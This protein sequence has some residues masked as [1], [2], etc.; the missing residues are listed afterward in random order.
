MKKS[1]LFILLALLMNTSVYGT[2]YI[3]DLLLIGGT[4]DEVCQEEKK[5]QQQGWETINKDLNEGCGESTDYIYLMA[6][7]EESNGVN[8]G[9]VTDV[10]LYTSEPDIDLLEYKGTVYYLTPYFGGSHFRNKKGNLNSHTGDNSDNIYLFYTKTL[11]DNKA[12]TSIYFNDTKSGAVGKNGNNSEGYDL[13]SGARGSYIYLHTTSATATAA[14][15]SGSG[16]TLVDPIIISSAAE[17]ATFASKINNCDYENSYQYVK[18]TS[19]IPNEKEKA[20]G[21]TAVTNM[22]ADKASAWFFFDGDNHTITVNINNVILGTA[23]F[24]RADNARFENLTIDGSVTSTEHHAAGLIGVCNGSAII[25]NCHISADVNSPTYAGGIVGH[26]GN[27][28][29]KLIM[30]KS[31]YDGTISGFNNYAGGLMGW[32]D[33]VELL[34]ADC[35]F[36]GSFQPGRTGQYNPIACKHAPSNVTVTAGDAYYL[37]TVSLMNIGS[38]AIPGLKATRVSPSMIPG[39]VNQQFNAPDGNT[40]Y[41]AY[42][43][44]DDMLKQLVKDH[45]GE[46]VSLGFD[47][48]VTQDF[49]KMI[50]LPIKVSNI[51]NGTLYQLTGFSKETKDGTDIWTATFYDVTP[52]QDLIPYTVPGVP[53]LFMP[54]NT[55][56]VTFYGDIDRVPQDVDEF[57][58]LQMDAGNGWTL[59]GVYSD[60]SGN[61][62]NGYLYSEANASVTD[63]STGE[64][65]YKLNIFI[66]IDRDN[67]IDAFHAYVS[68]CPQETG[69]S[70]PS[71]VFIDL[72]DKNG[73]ITAV[74]TIN[75]T[76]GEITIDRWYSI[77]GTPLMEQPTEPGIYIHN[78]KKIAI[79]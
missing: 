62:I 79:Q 32:C 45:P 37:E 57:E 3:T 16:K 27:L 19:D 23:P 65:L 22:V 41:S 40:Y 59:N 43:A 64:L 55:G 56:T 63:K 10:L 71:M 78:G 25:Q 69:A 49:P 30:N 61:Y 72:V 38:N 26:G 42:C 54:D 77:D 52:D 24:A 31:Y 50:C 74:G 29:H 51:Q 1:I 15:L 58:P 12:L 75:T 60:V 9:Y 46:K 36:K 68:Y 20:A 35:L 33:D 28:G 7:Y 21:K 14:S 6:K 44:H 5:F 48:S 13:N 66:K 4:W 73:N 8:Y 39:A 18:L 17:W 47:F 11:K 53:Y 76:T 70:I 34:I 67:T 2:R